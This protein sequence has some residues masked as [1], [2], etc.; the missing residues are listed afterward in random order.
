MNYIVC[1][2]Y[3][4]FKTTLMDGAVDGEHS[5]PACTCG[6]IRPSALQREALHRQAREWQG[7]SSKLQIAAMTF[8]SKLERC[9]KIPLDTI[10]FFPWVIVSRINILNMRS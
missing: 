9:E 4:S 3:A 8:L 2:Q 7:Q 5:R 10:L 1:L 6:I